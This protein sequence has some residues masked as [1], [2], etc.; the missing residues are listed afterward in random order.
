MSHWTWMLIAGSVLL[1][2]VTSECL[3]CRRPI[4][5]RKDKRCQ[6]CKEAGLTQRSPLP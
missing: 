6:R 3:V 1:F 2:V 4:W 5:R